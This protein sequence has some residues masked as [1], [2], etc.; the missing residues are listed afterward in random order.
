M[1]APFRR[2]KVMTYK[3]HDELYE[4]KAR[5]Y[6]RALS[7]NSI[8]GRSYPSSCSPVAGTRLNPVSGRSFFVSTTA[9]LVKHFARSKVEL[10]QASLASPANNSTRSSCNARARAQEGVL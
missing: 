5:N 1:D 6:R 3:A 9:P 2:R 7:R 8:T 4:D 10:R